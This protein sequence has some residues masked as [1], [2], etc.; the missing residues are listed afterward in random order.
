MQA[1]LDPLFEF[2]GRVLVESQQQDF[3]RRNGGA[4]SPRPAEE[5]QEVP[6]QVRALVGM[7][8]IRVLEGRPFLGER[9]ISTAKEAADDGTIVLFGRFLGSAGRFG[10][11]LG[12]A[13]EDRFGISHVVYEVLLI[14]GRAGGE[15][16]SMRQISQEQVLTSGGATRVVDRMEVAGFVERSVDPGDARARVVRLTKLGERKTVELSRWHRENVD[17]LFVEALPPERREAFAQD[18]H[19]LSRAAARILPSLP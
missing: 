1:V 12:G 7:D 3:L 17:R 11:A 18:L 19:A 13:M 2:L 9:G 4:G 15:G 10:H 16:V 5:G 6:A 14:I 8:S